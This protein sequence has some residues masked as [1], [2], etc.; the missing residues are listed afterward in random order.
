MD[1]LGL[2]F[3]GA[4][5]ADCGIFPHVGGFHLHEELAVGAL[6]DLAHKALLGADLPAQ[7][8]LAIV[9]QGDDQRLF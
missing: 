9:G 5:D 2:G 7:K 4:D 1:W 6:A 3:G 8:D